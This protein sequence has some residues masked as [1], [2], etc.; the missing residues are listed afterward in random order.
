MTNEQVVDISSDEVPPTE[1]DVDALPTPI[2]HPMT[3]RH[4]TFPLRAVVRG[5]TFSLQK[6]VLLCSRS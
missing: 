4:S 3:R 6:W 2:V 5:E 1:P